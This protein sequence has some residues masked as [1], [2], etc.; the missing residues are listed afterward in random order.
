MTPKK[1]SNLDNELNTNTTRPE[2]PERIAISVTKAEKE[3]AEQFAK[4]A[5]LRL[6][7]Y[8]RFKLFQ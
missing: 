4:K 2:R 7:D 6:S 5:H 1:N 8:A 3:A